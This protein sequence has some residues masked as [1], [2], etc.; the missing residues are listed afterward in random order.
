MKMPENLQIF[1]SQKQP[2]YTSFFNSEKLLPLNLLFFFS[3]SLRCLC[4]EKENYNYQTG[5]FYMDI[6]AELEKMG[7][8]IINISEAQIEENED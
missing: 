6:V 3:R 1:F 7:D 4:I 8:F 5:V 2:V